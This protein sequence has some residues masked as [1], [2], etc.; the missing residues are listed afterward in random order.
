MATKNDN[1]TMPM[2]IGAIALGLFAA[3][4]SVFYL[5]VRENSLKEQY[6]QDQM[7][8]VAVVV[9]KRNLPKGT[10]VTPEY[11]GVFQM[12]VDYVHDDAVAPGEFDRYIGRSLTANLSEGRTLLK[13]FM[14]AD[15]PV[16][17]SDIIPK[18]HR[19]MTISVDDINSIGGHLRPGN[20]VDLFVNIPFKLDTKQVAAALASGFSLELPPQITD[21]I[22]PELIAQIDNA[23]A[24]ET[25]LAG[26]SPSDLILPVIQNVRVLATGKDPYEE[27]LDSLRQPQRSREAHFS[28]ITLD[29][30][31]E[32]A[33]LLTLAIDKGE[34]FA[35]LRNRGDESASDFTY[36]APRDLLSNASD[37]AAAEKERASRVAEA[38]GVDINGNLV[39]ADGK[40]L[41]SAEQLAAAGYTVNENGQ[42]VDKDGNIIDPSDI[43]VAA[44]GTMMTKQ[45]LAA[46]GLTVNASGQI[47]DKDGN[48]VSADNIVMAADG[49]MMTKQ[50]LAAAGLSVNANGEI[51]DANGKVV[52]P[53]DII[54]RAD[55]TIISRQ[56][57]E[58]AG[59]TAAAGVDATGNLVDA[60]GNVLMSKEQLAA[61][62][63]SV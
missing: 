25:I 21:M 11:F 37:M 47:I 6:A 17:F 5:H 43:I 48:V 60:S 22:P 18:G 51:V 4:C 62:G 26:A 8:N 39:D 59:L 49:T 42:I 16:D 34:I 30:D 10:Q 36:V 52:S 58:A 55:G 50:Q 2:L 46:A 57:L 3:L 15:F 1:K 31:V 54:V 19:A 23:E 9:A 63:Y 53:D 14:E 41:V 44:D 35:L 20:R 7:G 24:L 29:V 38:A 45:Q 32:Q 12:P 40:T 61:A 27:T 28:T 33:G 56:Q 13:S